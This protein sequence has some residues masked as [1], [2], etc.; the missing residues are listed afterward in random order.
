MYGIGASGLVAQD[1]NAKL[2][3]LGLNVRCFTERDAAMVSASLLG[4]DDLAI[5]DLA[6]GRTPD[7][8][9]R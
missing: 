9:N 1:L 8:S 6:L 2:S 5:G 7:P 3:R 4:P